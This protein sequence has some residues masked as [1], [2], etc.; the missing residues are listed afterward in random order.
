[1]GIIKTKGIILSEHNMGDFDKMLTIL[2]PGM[3]KISCAAKGARR[4]KSSL[5]AGTQLLCFGEYLLYQGTSTYHINSCEIIEVFYKI[6]TDLEKLKYASHITKIIS[7]VTTE[8]QNN[9]KILQLY[10]NTLYMISETEINLN[11]ILAVFKIRLMTILGYAPNINYCV[12]CKE[13]ENLS[14][15]SL[16]YSGFLCSSCAKQD[17]GSIAISEGTKTAL[18]YIVLAPP[19]KLFSFQL[20]EESL[21]ELELIAKLY[22]DDK[23]E[24][25]YRIEEL[26]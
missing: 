15:F 6:R 3:G 4:P 12:G 26:F 2:T 5:L 9:Y 1:M 10:L 21:R 20:K 7:D 8:N 22:F 13:T 24:K 19:K 25:E 17:S 14:A 16:R 11:F 18:K 23:M